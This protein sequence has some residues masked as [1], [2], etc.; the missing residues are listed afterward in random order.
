MQTVDANFSELISPNF[1][2]TNANETLGTATT[3]APSSDS[4]HMRFQN[5]D[6]FDETS[7]SAI[8]P[9]SE[10]PIQRP[11]TDVL[12]DGITDKTVDTKL[13]SSG[14]GSALI[15]KQPVDT[16][17]TLR[18]HGHTLT[19]GSR[20]QNAGADHIN[21]VFN[22]SDMR[23]S[24]N[25]SSILLHPDHVD[26]TS[27][28][29]FVAT[30]V[31]PNDEMPGPHVISTES[32]TS[33]SQLQLIGTIL[34]AAQPG[35]SEVVLPNVLLD[36][37]TADITALNPPPANSVNSGTHSASPFLSKDK[38][39]SLLMNSSPL[40]P[41]VNLPS[42]P[43]TT[44][45]N[46]ELGGVMLDVRD[47]PPTSIL[48]PVA[49]NIVA[50]SIGQNVNANSI[51]IVPFTHNQLTGF[52]QALEPQQS[53]AI[54]PKDIPE[55]RNVPHRTSIPQLQ[56]VQTTEI[57]RPMDVPQA[58]D[59]SQLVDIPKPKPADPLQPHECHLTDISRTADTPDVP[60]NL[61]MDVN[62]IDVH[63]D[64]DEDQSGH[65]LNYH[66][67]K[68]K[69]VSCPV[70]YQLSQANALWLSSMTYAPMAPWQKLWRCQ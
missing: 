15:P 7:R 8:T 68:I 59:E 11:C 42:L 2:L 16:H 24:L 4:L 40:V 70:P 30:T 22:S 65:I 62:D 61:D 34:D 69:P 6:V 55:P 12:S 28:E 23:P 13:A 49:S 5:S 64:L 14:A 50:P 17:I 9:S 41:M 32:D 26:V 10:L 47:S 43:A 33:A 48:L 1:M 66:Q 57:S 20:S 58:M 25:T 39:P 67:L 38:A 31:V 45:P 19:S 46:K 27:S 56:T 29:M 53:A 63:G 44:S 52:R 35:Q 36:N 51:S 3:T 18:Y 21:A 60:Q 54:Q 37:R